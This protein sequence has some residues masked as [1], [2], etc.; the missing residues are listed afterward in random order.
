MSRR[1]AS[2]CP[3]AVRLR[4]PAATRCWTAYRR[5]LLRWCVTTFACLYASPA[6]STTRRPRRDG[7]QEVTEEGTIR[8]VEEPER[9]RG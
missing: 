9:S 4:W 3:V 8:L 6:T 7:T 2:A 1:A 5:R